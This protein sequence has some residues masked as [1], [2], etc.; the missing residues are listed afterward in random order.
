MQLVSQGTAVAVSQ[1]LLPFPL[2]N[3]ISEG[4]WVLANDSDS[5]YTPYVDDMPLLL[6][7]KCE[8]FPFIAGFP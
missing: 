6:P 7:L 5:S 8:L 1:L 3:V 4:M 2:G